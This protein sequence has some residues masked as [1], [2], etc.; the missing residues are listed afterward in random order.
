MRLVDAKGRPAGERVEA[1]IQFRGPSATAGYYR[2]P[3]ATAAIRTADGWLKTGD[4]G[5]L[6][7]GEL[8]VTGRVKDMIIKA[9]R[10]L[11]PPEVESA[12]AAV[13]GIRKGC[14]AAFGVPSARTG[15][16]DLVVVAETRQQD[17]EALRRLA[18]E[19][20]RRVAAEVRVSPD[21]VELVPPRTVP[22]TPSGKLRRAETRERY[23]A[24]ALTP[25]RLPVWVQVLRLAGAGAGAFL[26]ARLWR[27][28]IARWRRVEKEKAAAGGE[29]GA[30]ETKED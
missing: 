20:K 5:Y 23:L 2:N 7:D 9:G 25:R 3:K 4:R 17:P 24:G 6:A 18:S 1:E 19:V 11:H 21:A 14:V 29:P 13:D 26:L 10:N 22:K 30:E 16:E 8:Y 15:S 12:A 28:P 27:G